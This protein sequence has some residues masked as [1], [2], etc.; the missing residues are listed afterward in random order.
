MNRDHSLRRLLTLPIA[1]LAAVAVVSACSPND[2]S[3]S[4]PSS[5]V[6]GVATSAP[7]ATSQAA[8]AA[9]TVEVK[10][11]KF[12][13]ATVTIKVGQ[14]VTWKFDDNGIPHTVS[15]LRD[16]GMGIDSPIQRDGTYS[17]TF[18]TAGTFD[19]I[20]SLHPQMKGTVVVKP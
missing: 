11:M 16:V 18:D 20:C 12:S 6:P 9:A 3:K 13:P 17:H 15:G 1:T 5:T 8:A 7:T 10:D 19:Y 4:A 14:T 2:E